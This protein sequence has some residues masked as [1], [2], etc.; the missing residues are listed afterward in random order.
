VIAAIH[1]CRD[2]DNDTV[3]PMNEYGEFVCDDCV[4]N[5][6]EAAYERQCEAFHGGGGPLPLIEQQRQALKFK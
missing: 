4:Q 3:N 5:E 2:C 1:Q 6:A